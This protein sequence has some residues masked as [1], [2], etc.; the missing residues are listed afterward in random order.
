MAKFQK[1]QGGRPKGAKNLKTR[2][3][4]ERQ[5]AAEQIL[6]AVAQLP[7]PTPAPEAAVPAN[8]AAAK[9]AKRT[10]LNSGV[11]AM[12][13]IQRLS[14][15]EYEERTA[16]ARRLAVALEVLKL[17]HLSLVPDTTIEDEKKRETEFNER[18]AVSGE[19]V[20]AA[21][22]A[23]TQERQLARLAR[24]AAGSWGKDVAPYQDAKL[25]PQ[26]GSNDKVVVVNILKF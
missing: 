3:K 26:T 9:T 1:G 5:S 4:E 25:Q 12:A 15:V 18:K 7:A 19:A 24:D 23:L 22:D 6:D 21:T 14:W 8:K 2:A 10:P 17:T 20:K 16:T 13:E 11:A